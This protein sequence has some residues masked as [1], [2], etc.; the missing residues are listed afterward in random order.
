MLKSNRPSMR[1]AEKLG[2]QEYGF[3]VYVRLAS[4]KQA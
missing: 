1:L 4:V 2:F 3:S